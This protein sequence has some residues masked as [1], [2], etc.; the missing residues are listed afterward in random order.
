MFLA[1]KALIAHSFFFKKLLN[2]GVS[3]CNEFVIHWLFIVDV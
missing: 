1:L 2:S 3:I